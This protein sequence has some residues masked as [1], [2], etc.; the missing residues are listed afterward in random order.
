M[1]PHQQYTVFHPAEGGLNARMQRI[2]K[3]IQRVRP[4]RLVIDA[5]SELRILTKDPLRYGRQIL[6]LKNFMAD[7]S[8]FSPAAEPLL[9]TQ[10]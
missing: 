9:L 5:L 1:L 2:V 3:E 7:P 8:L 6:S 10:K 4:D